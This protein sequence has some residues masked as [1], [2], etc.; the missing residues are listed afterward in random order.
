M[1]RVYKGTR[2]G[3][4]VQFGACKDSQLAQDTAA[5]SGGTHTGAA[6]YLFIQSVEQLI[7]HQQPLT[8]ALP[9]PAAADACGLSWHGGIPTLSYFLLD[10]I[11]LQSTALGI[12]IHTNACHVRKEYVSMQCMPRQRRSGSERSMCCAGTGESSARC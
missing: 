12:S 5:L 2:G 3:L 7:A 8:C 1:C 10:A 9:P 11:L 4:A 6:T